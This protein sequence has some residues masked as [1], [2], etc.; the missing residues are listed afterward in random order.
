MYHSACPFLS[1]SLSLCLSLLSLSYFL[2]FLFFTGKPNPWGIK[3]WCAADPRSGYILDFDVYLGRIKEPMLHGLGYHVIMKMAE[4]YLGKGHHI[5]FDNLFSSVK[6]GQ[7][8]EKKETY[9][10]LTIRLNHAGWPKELNS[11]K[12]KVYLQDGHVV[13]TL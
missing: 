1:L 8:L 6:Q 13:A 2:L 4:D 5:F 3:V 10:C 11:T 12:A 7:D 9:M